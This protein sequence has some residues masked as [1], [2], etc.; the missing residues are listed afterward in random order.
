MGSLGVRKL[1]ILGSFTMWDGAG[2]EHLPEGL[3]DPVPFAAAVPSQAM[4]VQAS[5]NRSAHRLG[6][7]P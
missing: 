5:S 1:L 3:T 4:R 7:D 6:P 2:V